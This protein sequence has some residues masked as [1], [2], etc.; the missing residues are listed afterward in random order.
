MNYLENFQDTSD[1]PEYVIANFKENEDIKCDCEEPV[2]FQDFKSCES[3]LHQHFEYFLIVGEKCTKCS[4]NPF[5]IFNSP[6]NEEIPSG[7]KQLFE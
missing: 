7:L 2:K 4:K 3:I 5:I 1:N 6:G